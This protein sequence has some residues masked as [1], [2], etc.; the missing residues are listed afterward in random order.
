[1]TITA[2]RTLLKSLSGRLV[3]S[4]QAYPREPLRNA[5][6][7]MLF[8]QA[9]VAGGAAAIRAQGLEGAAS[10]NGKKYRVRPGCWP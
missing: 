8:A 1:M 3:V 5:H 7:M 10:E 4:C 9:A 2:Q 6:T